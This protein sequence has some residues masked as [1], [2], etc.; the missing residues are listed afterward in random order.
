MKII[1]AIPLKSI[2]DPL[3]VSGS[4][5]LRKLHSPFQAHA[6]FV[7][8]KSQIGENRKGVR[9]DLEGKDLWQKTAGCFRIALTENGKSFTSKQFADLLSRFSHQSVKLAFVVG[10]AFG[11][12]D[13]ITT[14]CDLALSLSAMTLPH[15]LAFLLLCE[16]LYRAHEILRGSP[17]HK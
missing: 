3:I 9:M 17:Y 8:A 6:V 13:D 2:K 16:Q 11:L 1:V 14:K 15:R 10:G 5:Y 7:D 12:S 4:E